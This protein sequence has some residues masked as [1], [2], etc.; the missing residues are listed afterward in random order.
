MLKIKIEKNIPIK[1]QTKISKRLLGWKYPFDKMKVG[2]S[3]F[4]PIKPISKNPKDN[5]R[6]IDKLQETICGSAMYY[7]KHVNPKF[8]YTTQMQASPPGVR[9]WRIK[10]IK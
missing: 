1:K 4:I 3:F 8:Q 7:K 6:L 5:Y 9:V 10:M 2:N